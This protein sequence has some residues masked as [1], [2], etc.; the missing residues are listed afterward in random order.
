VSRRSGTEPV[1]TI[2]GGVRLRLHVQP[3][4][5]RTEAAGLHGTALKVRLAAPP[6]DG[7]ANEALVRWIAQSLGVPRAAVTLAAGAGSR[8]K[9][10]DVA[11]ADPDDVRRRLGLDPR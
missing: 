11:G 6:V 8:T 3:R 7:A 5:T 4:A 10:V 9:T 2:P 1:E